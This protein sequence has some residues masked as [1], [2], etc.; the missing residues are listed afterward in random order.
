[1]TFFFS[2]AFGILM[3]LTAARPAGPIGVAL[4]A[5]SAVALFAGLFARRASVGAVLLVIAG[6]AMAAPSPFFAAVSGLSAAAYLVLRYADD[7]D[8]VAFT[9]PTVV[10]LLGFTAAG[11][12][13][14]AVSLELT[15][16]PLVAPAVVVVI[17]ILIAAPLWGDEQTGAISAP[18]DSDAAGQLP[19][20]D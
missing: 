13:A 5:V 12:A 7:S 11:V 16:I 1:M 4:L 18:T 3:V 20:G 8:A 10:G 14:T 15:W 19:A 2:Q 9:L 17:L 6:M